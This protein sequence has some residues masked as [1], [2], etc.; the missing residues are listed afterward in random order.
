MAAHS[1]ALCLRFRVWKMRVTAGL[2]YHGLKG[3]WKQAGRGEDP[4]GRLPG[5]L[6]ARTLRLPAHALCKPAPRQEADPVISAGDKS[7]RR[8]PCSDH[9][10]PLTLLFLSFLLLF[11]ASLLRHPPQRLQTSTHLSVSHGF[12]PELGA[13]TFRADQG[14]SLPSAPDGQV[15]STAGSLTRP[16]GDRIFNPRR[17][18][19]DCPTCF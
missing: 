16:G 5:T 4:V 19:R 13:Q 6:S 11:F 8:L 14:V 9:P 12:G 10:F 1:P 7:D 2:P 17:P 3:S 18:P 15:A